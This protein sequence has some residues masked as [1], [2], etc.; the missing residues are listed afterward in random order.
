MIFNYGRR[1]VINYLVGSALCWI[2][3]FHIDALRVDAVASMLYLDYSREED[4]WLPNEFGG[5][6]HLEAVDFLRQLNE[7]SIPTAPPAMRKSLP[8]GPV[9]HDPPM[10]AVSALPTNGTWAG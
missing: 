2:D 5:N 9:S 4:E 3:D 8:P 1:E 7:M 6:E 10:L